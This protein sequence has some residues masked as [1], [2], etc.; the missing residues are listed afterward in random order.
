[1]R[2]T[3]NIDRYRAACE[4]LIF[5]NFKYA[6][7][8]ELQTTLWNAHLKVNTIFRQEHRLVRHLAYERQKHD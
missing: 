6:S 5:S 3:T 4:A 7:A 8:H 2:T 1:M